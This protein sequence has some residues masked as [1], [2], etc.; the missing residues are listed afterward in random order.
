MSD[1]EYVKGTM[2]ISQNVGMWGDFVTLTKW[3]SIF[4]IV[5][6]AGMAIFLT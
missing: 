5:I 1:K 2:D 6:V 4:C 3:S